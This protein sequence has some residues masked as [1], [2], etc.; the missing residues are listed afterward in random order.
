MEAQAKVTIVVLV[1]C[2][3]RSERIVRVG[4][5][6][7]GGSAQTGHPQITPANTQHHLTFVVPGDT[8]QEENLEV[9]VVAVA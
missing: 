8:G 5:G 2:S 9:V 7:R 3:S 6:V 4:V 1:P